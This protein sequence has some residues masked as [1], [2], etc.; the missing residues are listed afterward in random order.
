MIESSFRFVGSL[1]ELSASPADW[2]ALVD[3]SPVGDPLVRSTTSAI[4]D[5]VRRDGDGALR[6]LARE[7]DGVDLECL[8]VPRAV[9]KRALDAL[10]PSVRRA[11]DRAAANLATAHRAFTPRPV[12]VEIEAGVIV[13]RRPDPL[14]VVGV[15]APGGR[16]AYPSSVLMGAVPARCAGVGTIVLCSPPG[17]DGVPASVVLAAAELGRV[18]RIFAIG[19]AG[20]IAAMGYGTETVPRVD[21]IVGP[22]NAYV[23]EAKLQIQGAGAAGIDSPAGP[24]ELLVL[25]DASADKTT[26]ARELLAQAEHDPLAA[27]W[28]VTDSEPLARAIAAEALAALSHQPRAS[29]IREAL[30]AR[31]AILWARSI[32]DAVEFAA[33]LAP[34]H[35]LL[36]GKVAE[37][38]LPDIRRAGTVFV[39]ETSSVTFGDYI[40][41]ANHVLPTGGSARSY[42]GLSTEDF[43]RWT[44]YQRVARDAARSLAPDVAL[45][46]T[47]EQLPGHAAAARAWSES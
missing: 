28:A 36:A 12:E 4:I 17:R 3:R 6:E 32:R 11:L 1:T 43:M 31:G 39:G 34:E 37:T 2:R 29:I 25:A 30:R 42:S 19:G 13:G 45:L 46:A 26:I 41:G 27:V 40:T 14:D 23:T 44:T 21:R 10:D 8:E 24:S 35:L 5:R 20:A 15:Y 16:G 18:D 9:A 7:L 22:G 47:A 38:V 33:E